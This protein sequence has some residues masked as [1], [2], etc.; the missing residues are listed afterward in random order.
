[1]KNYQVYVDN[2]NTS[3]SIGRNGKKAFENLELASNKLIQWLSEIK[4]KANPE[5]FQFH[6]LTISND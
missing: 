3:Y 1:M 2:N 6:V 4:I 5:K